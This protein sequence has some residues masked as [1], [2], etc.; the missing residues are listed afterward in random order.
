MM[1]EPIG[2]L[3]N[4][5]KTQ[6]QRAEL[7]PNQETY[8]TPEVRGPDNMCSTELPNW[9]GQVIATFL[10]FLLFLNES[11]YCDFIDHTIFCWT[12]RQETTYLSIVQS[13]E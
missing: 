6:Y 2:G 4:G 12:Y 3:N 5:L 9:Y 8:P 13:P 10:P 1:T 11:I 7:Y